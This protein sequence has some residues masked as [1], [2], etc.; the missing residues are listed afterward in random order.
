MGLKNCFVFVVILG[1]TVL[2]NN[3]KE[4]IETH[5]EESIIE[6]EVFDQV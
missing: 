5:D 2:I 3:M 1:N 4:L 6:R